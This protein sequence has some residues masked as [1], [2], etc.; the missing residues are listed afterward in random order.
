MA[1]FISTEE[2]YVLYYKQLA[3]QKTFLNVTQSSRHI[4]DQATSKVSY[5]YIDI[6]IDIVDIY[7]SYSLFLLIFPSSQHSNTQSKPNNIN[8]LIAPL[9]KEPNTRL[10]ILPRPSRDRMTLRTN[11]ITRKNNISCLTC[12]LL[13]LV[14]AWANTNQMVWNE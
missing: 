13:D 1:C 6:S 5:R 3:N 8:V 12:F 7:A 2:T 4:F 14:D 10:Q 11:K 9:F